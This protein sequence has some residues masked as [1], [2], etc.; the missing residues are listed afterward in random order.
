MPSPA[1][2]EKVLKENVLYND[3]EVITTPHV[4]VFVT[5]DAGIAGT[6][7]GKIAK[8]HYKRPEKPITGFHENHMGSTYGI[9]MKK[10]NMVTSR[11]FAEVSHDMLVMYYL[12]EA[13]KG[14]RKW[15]LPNFARNVDRDNSALV[16]KLI[17]DMF[18]NKK[19]LFIVPSTWLYSTTPYFS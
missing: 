11:P 3:D 14:E 2:I 17:K 12:A 13:D 1:L 4:F 6:D 18:I 16:I 15:V 9:S 5:N 19:E 10:A 8:R 7:S